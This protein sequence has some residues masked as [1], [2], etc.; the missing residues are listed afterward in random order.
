MPFWHKSPEERNVDIPVRRRISI[1]KF[2]CYR[3][4]ETRIMYQHVTLYFSIVMIR[5]AMV[6]IERH[7]RPSIEL[8]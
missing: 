4:P 5:F 7:V 3:Q 8:G 1:W 2:G 6:S